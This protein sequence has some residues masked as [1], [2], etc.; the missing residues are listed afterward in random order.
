MKDG[1][2]RMLVQFLCRR[3]SPCPFFAPVSHEAG[4]S[5]RENRPLRQEPRGAR[6]ARCHT[7]GP[8]ICP[9]AQICSFRR[10][11]P[12]RWSK[13]HFTLSTQGLRFPST[14]TSAPAAGQERVPHVGT[15]VATSWRGQRPR[16]PDQLARSVHEEV[17]GRRGGGGGKKNPLI[18]EEMSQ[19]RFVNQ[20][21]IYNMQE[22]ICFIFL[23]YIFVKH[24]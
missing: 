9:P 8:R 6:P 5:P 11:R 15:R 1:T 22:L 7:P 14:P 17:G 24:I 20:K 23:S 3:L 18:S 12:P 19:I 21:P 2:Q 4:L 10:G 16:A 13:D